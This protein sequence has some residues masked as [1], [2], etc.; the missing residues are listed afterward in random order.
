MAAR[1]SLAHRWLLILPFLWQVGA[2]PLVNEVQAAPLHIPFPM[3]WQM[4]GVV[5]TSVVI[6][7]VYRLDRA[8]GAF[9]HDDAEVDAAA[10]GQD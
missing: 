7:V 2:V 10:E 8:A 5:L 9:E 1:R 4:L 3:F 6:G